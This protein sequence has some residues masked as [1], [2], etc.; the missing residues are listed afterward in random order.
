MKLNELADG[1]VVR[2]MAAAT[3]QSE[4]RMA[5]FEFIE[6]LC[7]V[8]GENVAKLMAVPEDGHRIEG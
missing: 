4:A 7:E 1:A 5:V 3:T 8:H 6:G 2:L